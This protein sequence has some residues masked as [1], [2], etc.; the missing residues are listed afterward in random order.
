MKIYN[1]SV[2]KIKGAL[3]DKSPYEELERHLNLQGEDGY[4]LCAAIPQVYEGST[5]ATVLIFE[6]EDES[7]D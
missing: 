6:S 2:T 5:E 4:R 3:T 1:Y 7:E